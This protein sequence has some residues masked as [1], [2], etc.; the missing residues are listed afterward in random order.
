M[1][2]AKTAKEVFRDAGAVDNMLKNDILK[3]ADV[4]CLAF[5]NL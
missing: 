4:M 2:A 3:G 1:R 5:F